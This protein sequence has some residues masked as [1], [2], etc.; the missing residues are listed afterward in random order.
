MYTEIKKKGAIPMSK[1]TKGL[2]YSLL[3]GGVAVLVGVGC[4]EQEHMVV[5]SSVSGFPVVGV[6]EKAF[7]RS[8]Q[9]K[10][11]RFP[12][13][14]RFVDSEAFAWCKD[15]EKVTFESV[16][17]IGDR[18]DRKSTRLNSSHA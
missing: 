3:D 14:V 2:E 12:S 15:L 16:L 10:S 9:V 5:P 17:E 4:C 8:Q 13:S 18:A 11:I 7:F 1:A 6:A